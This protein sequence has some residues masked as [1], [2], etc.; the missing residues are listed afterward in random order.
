MRIYMDGML[1][2]RE[3]VIVGIHLLQRRT[4]DG[5][6]NLLLQ[7]EPL[8]EAW[9]REPSLV[10]RTARGEAYA[11][12][13]AGI[14]VA[15]MSAVDERDFFADKQALSASPTLH[16]DGKIFLGIP[17]GFQGRAWVPGLGPLRGG[18][19]DLG[20]AW[21]ADALDILVGA[22]ARGVEA[23]DETR[24]NAVGLGGHLGA[25]LHLETTR[26]AVLGGLGA[27]WSGFE[28]S[29][30]QGLGP[31]HVAGWAGFTRSTW[32]HLG[33]TEAI[34]ASQYTGGI[35]AGLGRRR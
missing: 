21:R 3:P 20:L 1:V 10:V 32:Q 5:W 15:R 34:P 4:G 9:L 27:G 13:G 18:A 17:L 25:E 29:V 12:L 35:S 30:I 11:G 16:L 33:G 28:A 7:D 24:H 22:S 6:T 14:G 26:L 31:I 19:A 23:I 2:E 8:P